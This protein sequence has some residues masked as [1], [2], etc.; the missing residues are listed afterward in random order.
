MHFSVGIHRDSEFFK[1][2]DENGLV[3]E[4]LYLRRP[5]FSGM[6]FN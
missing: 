1:S 5:G 3:A 2:L 6:A 4:L